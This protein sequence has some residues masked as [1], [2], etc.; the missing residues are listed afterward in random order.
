MTRNA[1][2]SPTVLCLLAGLLLPAGHATAAPVTGAGLNRLAAAISQAPAEVR[3]DFAAVAL[4]ELAATHTAEADRARAEARSRPGERDLLSWAAA[5]DAYARELQALAE[6]IAGAAT[7]EVGTGLGPEAV[8]HIG[9]DGRLVMLTIPRP[10]QR[11]VFEQRVIEQFCNRFRCE[12]YLSDHQPSQAFLQPVATQPRWSFSQ[13]AGP[14]CSTGDGLVFQFT[15]TS[16]LA[17]KRRACSRVAGELNMLAGRLASKIALGVRIDWNR[18]A[19]LDVPGETRQLVTLNGDG[20]GLVLP[21]PA[22]AGAP[23][24]F[25]LLRPWLAAR[26]DGNSYRLVL[27]NSD[28][29]MRPVLQA[30][31]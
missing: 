3:A 29:L 2:I 15:N 1:A 23:E 24:L 20:E 30:E 14:A 10:R 19:V 11:P 27:L 21:L 9:I 25:R 16:D 28:D 4:A 31:D 22:L 8:V 5:A 18:L 13:Q 12:D 6:D 7:L 17:L 26:V